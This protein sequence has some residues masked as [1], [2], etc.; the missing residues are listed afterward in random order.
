MYRRRTDLIPSPTSGADPG[1]SRRA[2]LG[3]RTIYGDAAYCIIL[4]VVTTP[5]G[6]SGP[7]VDSHAPSQTAGSDTTRV[8]ALGDLRP[9][10][11]ERS[12]SA[13]GPGKVR[14]H[15]D[16]HLPQM[17]A[18]VTLVADASCRFQAMTQR[19]SIHMQYDLS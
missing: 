18:S 7:S 5:A 12:F 17:Q 16:M 3:K 14:D 10:R 15:S 8:V 2:P 19:V 6:L 1:P 11:D 4:P 13:V 9:W